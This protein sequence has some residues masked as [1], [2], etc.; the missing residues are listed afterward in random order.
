MI[1][2]KEV[3]LFSLLL[4]LSETSSRGERNYHRQAKV[5]WLEFFVDIPP[6][7]G[8]GELKWATAW[9]AWAGWRVRLLY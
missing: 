4:P 9:L 7:R 5:E 8:S 6:V 1:S 2:S 3:S